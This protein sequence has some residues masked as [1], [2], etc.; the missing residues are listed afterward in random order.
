MSL[1]G[2]W[3][4]TEFGSI[5]VGHGEHVDIAIASML[6]LNQKRAPHLW[7]QNGI[8]KEEL[9]AAIERG[10]DADAV[11][12]LSS[13]GKDARLWVIREL[14]WIRTARSAWNVWVFDDHVAEIARKAKDYWRSQYSMNNYDTIDVTELKTGDRF[15]VNA[16]KLQD[17]GNPHVL[18]NLAMGRMVEEEK[19][20]SPVVYST[21]RFSERERKRL[22]SRQGD[23]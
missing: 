7:N 22:Y 10:A 4:L 19:E 8:P 9:A 23:N 20:S 12:F 16:K 3:W 14:G 18:K 2:K 13:K 15:A 11:D 17:G 21:S 1:I 5:D 6:L